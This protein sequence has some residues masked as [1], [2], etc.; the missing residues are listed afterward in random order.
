MPKI[1]NFVYRDLENETGVRVTQ[2][3]WFWYQWKAPAHIPTS[4]Q[5]QLWSYLAPFWGYGGL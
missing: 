4:D 1:A 2:G 3:H 5:Q